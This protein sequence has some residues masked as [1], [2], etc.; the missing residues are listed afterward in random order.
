MVEPAIAW[1]ILLLIGGAVALIAI[2]LFGLPQ[3]LT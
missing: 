3:R 2:L 1:A